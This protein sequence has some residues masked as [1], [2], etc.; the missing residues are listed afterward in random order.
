M[1]DDEPPF[2]APITID[3]NGH[4]FMEF[5]MKIEKATIINSQSVSSEDMGDWKAGLNNPIHIKDPMSMANFTSVTVYRIVTVIV[6]I[7]HLLN[8]TLIENY[9]LI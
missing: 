2:Y 8:L 4:S 5:N 7:F 3:T 6:R 9:S 1:Q